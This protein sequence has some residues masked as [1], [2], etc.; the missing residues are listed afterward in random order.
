MY[1][2]SYPHVI[3]DNSKIDNE[4]RPFVPGNKFCSE[5][6][7]TNPDFPAV[8]VKCRERKVSYL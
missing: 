5:C 7:L 2:E 6:A 3:Y 8:P 1:L 4:F